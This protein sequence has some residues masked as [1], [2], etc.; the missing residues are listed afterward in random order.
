MKLS[1]SY[2]VNNN[3][4]DT[5]AMVSLNHRIDSHCCSFTRC[6][7][8]HFNHIWSKFLMKKSI[9]LAVLASIGGLTDEDSM[10]ELVSIGTGLLAHLVDMD[11]DEQKEILSAIVMNVEQGQ[12]VITEALSV[13]NSMIEENK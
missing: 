8:S 11:A 2:G 4:T 9:A 10:K 13:V 12:K 5:P 7:Q 3:E 1:Q 6:H